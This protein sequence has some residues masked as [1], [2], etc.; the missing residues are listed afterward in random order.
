V[1]VARGANK[2]RRHP[3]SRVQRQIEARPTPVS[4]AISP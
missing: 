3:P 2:C 1:S 4:A